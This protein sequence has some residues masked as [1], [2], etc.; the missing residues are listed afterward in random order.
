MPQE[1]RCW[2]HDVDVLLNH[3][4]DRTDSFVLWVKA[5]MLLSRVKTF[6]V[7]W[8]GR[9]HVR[10]PAY[11]SPI[12]TSESDGTPDPR[13]SPAFLELEQLVHAFRASFPAHLRDPVQDGVVDPHLYGAHIA[14]N[15]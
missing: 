6:N 4:P 14:A 15:M 10:D 5:V 11:Y 13:D 2:S 3:P 7:R 12:D 8:R 9:M 1:E